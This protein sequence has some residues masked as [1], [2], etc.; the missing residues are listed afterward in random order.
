M[1]W[2]FDHRASSVEVN[3]A[4]LQV[5]ASSVSISAAEHQDPNF[6]PEPQ[7][8][9]RE[10][11]VEAGNGW[12]IAFRD[13]TNPTNIRTAIAAIVP[14]RIAG[15]T[16]PLL[17]P[18]DTEAQA[19]AASW[20]PLLLANIN[21]LAFDYVTRQK[22][23]W[24]HLNWFILE[25]LPVIAPE[26]FEQSIGGGK[27]AD[28]IRSQVLAL[29]YTAHDMAPFACDMGYV[30]ESGNH[31]GE[32]KLPF[33]WNEEDRR[34]R[35]AALDALF[36]HLY[37]INDADAAYIMDTF[38]IVREHDIKA[39]GRYRTREDV[40]AQLRQIEKGVLVISQRPV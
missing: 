28:F 23:K 2:H 1:I 5:A 36:F 14:Y 38:P 26:C 37:G 19:S 32:V 40:L 39:F 12:S 18:K 24:T 3:L 20:A 4:N 21:S 29:T 33:V 11:A 25:Q 13:I 17:L 10:D 9:V 7:F 15:N 16:L 34:T 8:W 22:A 6:V 27:I 31:K 30:H 35:L